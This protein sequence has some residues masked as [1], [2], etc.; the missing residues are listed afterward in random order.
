MGIE[1]LKGFRALGANERAELAHASSVQRVP[2]GK[3]LF[4]EGQ[5]ADTVWAVKEGLIHI[6]KRGADGREV[7]LEVF[8]PGEIF[9]AV[10]VLEE[11]AYPV[12]AVAA[13]PSEV[14]RVPASVVRNLA[15]RHPTL[16]A[17]LLQQA[18]ARLR[19]AQ[20]RLRSIALERVEQRLARALLALADKIGEQ[21]GEVVE[22]N[23]TRQELAD[24]VG[25]TV[26]TA[27]RVTSKWQ[28]AGVLQSSRH[29]VGLR[30]R[31][32]L[33]RIAGGR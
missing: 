22:V 14:W 28:R 23:L 33:Q 31:A 19:A 32:Q 18:S 3:V 5:P 8:A 12:S 21:R 30:D 2:S 11:R 20:D 29:R 27:I 9:A 7:I 10:A 17:A 26:E 4:S 24:M 1:G 13:A 16:R 15:L 25:T 6:V